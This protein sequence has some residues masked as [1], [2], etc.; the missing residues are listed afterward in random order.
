MTPLIALAE[1]ILAV[2]VCIY[3]LFS[4]HADIAGIIAAIIFVGAAILAK[5]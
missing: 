1:L 5:D 4:G 3:C 2:A